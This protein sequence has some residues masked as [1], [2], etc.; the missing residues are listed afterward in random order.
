M[1]D[2]EI[3]TKLYESVLQ[4]IQSAINYCFLLNG[5][6]IISILTFIG[7]YKTEQP[8]LQKLSSSIIVLTV[9]VFLAVLSSII[10]YMTQLSYFKKETG[11]GNPF[12]LSGTALRVAL[13]FMIVASAVLFGIGAISAS[14]S[15]I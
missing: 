3:K 8:I 12:L 7:N 15:L 4:S 10:L 14:R 5:T 6:A 9:G 1:A 2:N 13:L 11:T